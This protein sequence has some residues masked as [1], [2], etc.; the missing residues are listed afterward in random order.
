MLFRSHEHIAARLDYPVNLKQKYFQSFDN[1]V[2][3]QVLEHVF[4]PEVFL[5][6]IHRVIKP[7]GNMLMSVPFIWDEHE[8]PWD[9]ARYSSFGL[10]YLLENTGFEVIEQRKL[11]A[12]VSVHSHSAIREEQHGRVRRVR[13]ER[14]RRSAAAR[15]Q[16]TAR[17]KAAPLVARN[18]EYV[19]SAAMVKRLPSVLSCG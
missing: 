13:M 3:N 10:K 6:E 9:Y 1:V 14:T 15:L 5:L 17:T 16:T 11:N 7:G 2:C 12:C 18:K 4:R 19:A 8:Q